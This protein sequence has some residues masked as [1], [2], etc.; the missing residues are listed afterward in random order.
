MGYGAGLEFEYRHY[1][2][3]SERLSSSVKFAEIFDIITEDVHAAN[4]GGTYSIFKSDFPSGEA[5]SSDRSSI[6]FLGNQSDPVELELAA[7]AV[8]L[9]KEGFDHPWD[10]TENRKPEKASLER[11]ERA[12]ALLN[13]FK[14]LDNKKMLPEFL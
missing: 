11:I 4:W 10:E 12:K 8:Y 7:T 13:K 14:D 5:L 6:V 9:A 2:P 3:Y 1:G